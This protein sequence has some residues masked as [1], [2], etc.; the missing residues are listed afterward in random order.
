MKSNLFMGLLLIVFMIV[1]SFTLLNMLIGVIC[2]NVSETKKSEEEKL[3]MQKV[4]DLFEEMGNNGGFSAWCA[5]PSK[6]S[7]RVFV[8][9]GLL[10]RHFM[11]FAL[12]LVRFP[13]KFR[14]IMPSGNEGKS[15]LASIPT[16]DTIFSDQDDSGT[17]SREEFEAKQVPVIVLS[18]SRVVCD[19]F[20]QSSID[21]PFKLY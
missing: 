2:E 6:Y 21:A 19:Y 7:F 20:S 13:V 18:V 9:D 16:P 1:G 4:E 15:G 10:W 14:K 12:A 17:I 8:F 11:V 3:L 5:K